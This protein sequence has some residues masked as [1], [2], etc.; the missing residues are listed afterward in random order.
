MYKHSIFNYLFLTKNGF[1][2]SDLG[3]NRKAVRKNRW[4]SPNLRRKTGKTAFQT[5]FPASKGAK[6]AAG[7]AFGRGGAN[8]LMMVTVFSYSNF[9]DFDDEGCQDSAV[10][11]YLEDERIV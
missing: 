7:A 5:P 11:L 4:A 6:K 10:R 1:L 3:K 2:S 8:S 9:G